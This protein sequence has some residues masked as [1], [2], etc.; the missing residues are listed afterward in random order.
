MADKKPGGDEIVAMLD[1]AMQDE[2][3]AII[4]YLRH[5]YAMGEGEMACE[6]EAIARE[7]MYHF[8]W[9]GKAVVGLG[10]GPDMARAFVDLGGET[11][12]EWMERD[13]AAEDRA[14][15]LYKESLSI[16][17]D[18]RLTRLLSRILSD[19][20]SHRGDFAHFADK[21]QAAPTPEQDLTKASAPGEEIDTLNVG[22]Q[23][24]Y[25]VILQYLHHTFVMP[26]CSISRELELRAINEMQHM[27]WL[28]EKV[29]G[30]GGVPLTEHAELEL[31]S[32]T[33]EMLEADIRAERGVTADYGK[34]A[35]AMDDPDLRK[36]FMRMQGHEIYH[37][38]LF[39]DMLREVRAAG[40][41][42]MGSK[43]E[44]EGPAKEG[45]EQPFSPQ[46]KPTVG[47]LIE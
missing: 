22:V 44:T 47:S 43:E 8:R 1:Q 45:T 19:E 10:G 20:E 13:V 26:E 27:G 30:R 32:E 24:E 11:I 3:A 9:L 36:L 35:A 25:T 33:A 15:E 6:I 4:Q 2:H 34:F 29:A 31:P 18:L 23:H 14:I 16:S 42:V 38:E 5:A 40:E 17:D 7:E 41:K 46:S 21:S 37:D 28:S 12:P 39:S